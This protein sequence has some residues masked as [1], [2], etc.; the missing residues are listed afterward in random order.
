MD[1]MEDAEDYSEWPL[2][3][4]ARDFGTDDDY[5]EQIPIGIGP[6]RHL[7]TT[8]GVDEDDDSLPVGPDET[9]D[10]LPEHIY[11]ASS[12]HKRKPYT[13]GVRNQNMRVFKKKATKF[14]NMDN[15]ISVLVTGCC[16]KKRCLTCFEAV[17]VMKAREMF[18]SL[19]QPEQVN[20]LIDEVK[21]MSI[22]TDDGDI[23]QIRWPFMNKCV[24]SVAFGKLYGLGTQRTS[25]VAYR[26]RNGIRKYVHGLVKNVRTLTVSSHE[27]LSW[28][29]KYF[30]MNAEVMPNS[31]R[32]HLADSLTRKAVYELFLLR[33]RHVYAGVR[34]PSSS[35]FFEIWRKECPKICIPSVKRFSV[36][37]QCS[38][39]KASRDRATNRSDRGKRIVLSLSRFVR[40]L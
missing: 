18:W 22:Y 21:R 4:F 36:C 30:A 6:N 2:I 14:V 28:M 9:L 32:Y 37:A 11:E 7:G 15:I 12:T 17:D 20:Y 29:R 35:R 3:P 24:C 1:E 39:F 33:N 10:S 26:V 34:E 8:S 38:R 19:K 25:D 27:I 16:K 40:D 31:D 23:K 13:L 5:E